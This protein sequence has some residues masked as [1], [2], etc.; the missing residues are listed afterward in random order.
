MVKLETA[1]LLLALSADP[2][3]KNKVSLLRIASLLL[4]VTRNSG[5]IFSL[6]FVQD[7]KTAFDLLEGG[8]AEQI[9]QIVSS[10][11]P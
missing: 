11:Y 3:L 9:R 2:T 1:G 6:C 10:A 7:G 4:L 5:A 8:K